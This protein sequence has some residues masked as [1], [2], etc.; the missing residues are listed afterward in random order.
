MS[1]GAIPSYLDPDLVRLAGLAVNDLI[2]K[3]AITAQQQKSASLSPEARRALSDISDTFRL[4][5]QTQL[6]VLQSGTQ[7]ELRAAFADDPSSLAHALT[8]RTGAAAAAGR[9]YVRT[10][11]PS[12][13]VELVTLTSRE[14]YIEASYIVKAQVRE[15]LC[16]SSRDLSPLF[17][18]V[19]SRK[20]NIEALRDDLCGQHLGRPKNGFGYWTMETMAA[21]PKL[22]LQALEGLLPTLEKALPDRRWGLNP[23]G[24]YLAHLQIIATVG[25]PKANEILAREFLAMDVLKT[26]IGTN[27]ASMDIGPTAVPYGIG[28]IAAAKQFAATGDRAFLQQFAGDLDKIAGLSQRSHHPLVGE[29]ASLNKNALIEALGV[30]ASEAPSAKAFAREKLA[31]LVGR[32]SGRPDQVMKL[33]VALQQAGDGE[34]S[35]RLAR[36]AL[37]AAESS[38]PSDANQ[39]LEF[40]RFTRQAHGAIFSASE[41]Q[42]FAALHHL[43]EHKKPAWDQ[44]IAAWTVPAQSPVEAFHRGV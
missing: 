32:N 19:D 29:I 39:S 28:A 11:D 37:A 17:A 26:C 16:T 9:A 31:P 33:S 2:D 18:I 44:E 12:R 30:L 42:D 4:S 23:W 40:L 34:S 21:N 22:R 36:E 43:S 41:L 35:V 8:G 14:P 10:L 5:G 20:M 1:S 6:S 27:E 7:R 3:S 38:K 24:N 13:L 25:G 15:V